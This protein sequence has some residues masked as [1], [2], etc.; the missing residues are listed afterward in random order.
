MTRFE[1]CLPLILHSEGGYVDDPEDPGG[2]TNL[3]VTIGTLS[4]WLKRP[5]TKAEVKALT[6]A[7][8]APIYEANYWHAAAC[9]R[10]PPGLDYMVFDLAVNSG[11][12]RA[13]KM[14]QDAVGVLADGDIGPK[15][16]EAVK[17]LGDRSSIGRMAVRRE[18]FYRLQPTFGR[19]GKGWL[20]RLAEVR[21]K[22]LEMAA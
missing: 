7:T 3:G 17:A 14:L 13:K 11:T 15:T 19:F 4:D 20:N 8:V 16:L 22:A 5:A 6:P 9:D 21:A 1:T 2:A 12:G 18:A 10:L